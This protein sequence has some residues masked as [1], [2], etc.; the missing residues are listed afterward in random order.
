LPWSRTRLARLLAL[1]LARPA[2]QGGKAATV[3]EEVE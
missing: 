3:A 2:A 1:N